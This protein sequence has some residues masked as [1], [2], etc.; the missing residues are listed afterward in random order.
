MGFRYSPFSQ[1]QIKV[2]SWWMPGNPYS[3]ADGIICDGSV[4]AGKTLVESLSFVMWA[5][6][7]DGFNYAIT[8][9]TVMSA[10]RNIIEPLTDPLRLRGYKVVDKKSEGKLLIS[11]K[12]RVNTFYIF[13]GRDESS[14][15]LIQGLTLRGVLFDEVAL[16]PKSFVEQAMARC[17][18]EGAKLWFNCN[19]EGPRHW[20]KKEHIDRAKERNYLH[21]HFGL[22]DNPSLS[23]KTKQRYRNMFTGIFYKRFILGEWAFADGIVYPDIPEGT[24]YTNSERDKVVPIKIIE[25]DIQPIYGCDYGTTNPQIYLEIYKYYK[26]GDHIPYFYVDREYCWN[27]RETLRTKTDYEYVQEF[28]AWRKPKY[29]GIYMDPA[30]ESLRVAHQRSGDLVLPAKNDVLPGIS[31]VSTLFHLGHIFINS[32]ECPNLVAE[33]GLYQWDPKKSE[34]GKEQVIKANDHSCDALRYAIFTS[35]PKAEVFRGMGYGRKEKETA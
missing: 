24:Y 17:S 12:G 32:D 33:L 28:K 35:T 31:M 2:L 11:F 16:M 8:G 7:N 5:M 21:L 23:E 10:R 25:G 22:D 9:K 6:Q 4:R 13:G 34:Q 20:F 27:S 29:R 14:A 18:V 30:A 19:P 1:K 15:S 3:E 26:P